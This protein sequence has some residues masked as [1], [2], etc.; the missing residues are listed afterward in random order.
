MKEKKEALRTTSR[1]L[2]LT[3]GRNAPLTLGEKVAL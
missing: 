3:R 1:L 2:C